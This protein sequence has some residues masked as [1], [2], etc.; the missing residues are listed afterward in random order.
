MAVRPS[1][2][3]NCK[4]A[5]SGNVWVGRATA[6]GGTVD[7]RDLSGVGVRSATGVLRFLF[8]GGR[9]QDVGWKHQSLGQPSAAAKI[10]PKDSLFEGGQ[11]NP[12]KVEA[13][14][15]GVYF[16]DG[17]VCGETGNTVKLRYASIVESA[18]Q[19]VNDVIGAANLLQPKQFEEAVRAGVLKTGPYARETSDATN[20]R[21]KALLLG[22]DGKLRMEYKQVLKRWQDSFKP[23]KPARQKL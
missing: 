18:E 3:D 21:A 14:V 2:G 4:L 11:V 9:F 1:T 8:A 19:D 10:T 15:L 7:L 17:S 20:S 13:H 22:P 12:I 5:L 23:A 6:G 16:A